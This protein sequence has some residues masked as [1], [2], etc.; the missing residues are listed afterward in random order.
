M[1]AHHTVTF[2]WLLRGRQC[3][4]VNSQICLEMA[5]V[6]AYIVMQFWLA[7]IGD[8]LGLPE[9]EP[10]ANGGNLACTLRILSNDRHLVYH[11]FGAKFDAIRRALFCTASGRDLH[12]S[13]PLLERSH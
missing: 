10:I 4:P 9:Q 6:S 1:G 8:I 2:P 3:V 5:P 12:T 7:I 11:T 13:S